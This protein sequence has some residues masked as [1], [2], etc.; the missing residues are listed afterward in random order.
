MSMK[1]LQSELLKL[2]SLGKKNQNSIMQQ[3]DKV[4]TDYGYFKVKKWR[5]LTNSKKNSLL[6]ELVERDLLDVIRYVVTTYNYDINI[7]RESDGYTPYQLASEKQN[8]EI[9]DALEDL[10]ADIMITVDV[11]KWT[12]DEDTKKIN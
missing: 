12:L 11:S 6:H 8:S 1:Q 5:N 10:G 9:C 3:L 4:I 2:V 7:R